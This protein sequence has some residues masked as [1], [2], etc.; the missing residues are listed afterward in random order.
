MMLFA[1]L[2]AL[3]DTDGDGKI[4]REEMM[5]WV[6]GIHFPGDGEPGQLQLIGTFS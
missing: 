1:D 6:M 4:S 3:M 5:A 2:F